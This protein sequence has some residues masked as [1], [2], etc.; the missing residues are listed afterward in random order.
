MDSIFSTPL[1]LRSLRIPSLLQAARKEWKSSNC[2]PGPQSS[3]VNTDPL[4]TAGHHQPSLLHQPEGREESR[5]PVHLHAGQ[6]HPQVIPGLIFY[7]HFEELRYIFQ[8]ISMSLLYCFFNSEVQKTIKRLFK[9][10]LT[11]FSV[12]RSA[13]RYLTSDSTQFSFNFLLIRNKSLSPFGA[14]VRGG[15]VLYPDVPHQSTLITANFGT[16]MLSPYIW[17]SRFCRDFMRP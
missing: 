14:K 8:G 12:E 16:F 10:N 17:M 2:F 7:D 1:W 11:R 13:T 4:P 15:E 5:G 9:R 3:P 6:L